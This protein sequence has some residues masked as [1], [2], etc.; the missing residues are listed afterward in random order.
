MPVKL[1][2][3]KAGDNS[4]RVWNPQIYAADKAHKMPVITPAYPSMCSTHNVTASTK[5]V[6]TEEFKRGVEITEKIFLGSATW[7]DLFEKNDFFHRYKYYLQIIA[8]SDSAERHLR[9]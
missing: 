1:K 2:D 7:N 3:I 8:S 6:T 4:L 9:W 5:Y